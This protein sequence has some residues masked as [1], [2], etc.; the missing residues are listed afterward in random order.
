V[1]AEALA[2]ARKL[3]PDQQMY[4]QA[5]TFADCQTI[6]NERQRFKD[7]IKSKVK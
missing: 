4:M 7:I 6:E 1:L 2:K 5:V 3:H